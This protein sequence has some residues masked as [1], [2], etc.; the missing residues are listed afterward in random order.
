MVQ[1]LQDLLELRVPKEVLLVT[2]EDKGHKVLRGHKVLKAESQDM[3]VLKVLK[4]LQ[5][6]L[7]LKGPF[8]DI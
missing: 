5:E 3:L 2:Q 4:V 6:E 7:E 8:K 1:Y